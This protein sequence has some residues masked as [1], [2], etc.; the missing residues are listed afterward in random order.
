[1]TDPRISLS[2]LDCREIVGSLLQRTDI[3]ADLRYRRP[4]EEWSKDE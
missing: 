3:A 1:M 4:T 2:E